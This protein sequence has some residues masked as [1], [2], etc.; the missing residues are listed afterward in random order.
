VRSLDFTSWQALI[1]ILLGLSV[2]TLIGVGIRV[3][4]DEET[5]HHD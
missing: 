4:H 5:E 1:S 2:T 3:S